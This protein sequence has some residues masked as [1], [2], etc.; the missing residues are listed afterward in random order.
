MYE[1]ECL[2]DTADDKRYYRR[3]K[4]YVISEDHPCKRWFRRIGAELPKREVD[5]IAEEGAPPP[6]PARKPRT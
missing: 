4:V 5:R 1:A 6:R 3:G 2:R